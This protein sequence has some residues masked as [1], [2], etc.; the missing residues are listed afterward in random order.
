[1]GKFTNI[2]TT[3]EPASTLFKEEINAIQA[4]IGQVFEQ[5]GNPTH[6]TFILSGQQRGHDAVS[7]LRFNLEEGAAVVSDYTVGYLMQEA[8]G[9]PNAYHLAYGYVP[10]GREFG[11]LPSDIYWTQF[12]DYHSHTLIL[13]TTFGR[14]VA[15]SCSEQDGRVDSEGDKKVLFAV[16]EAI[17]QMGKEDKVLQQSMNSLR[18]S[19]N[20]SEK[21]ALILTLRLFD[22]CDLPALKAWREW[23]E[24]V[25][26]NGE[27]TLFFE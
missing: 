20:A 25:N 15:C 8:L 22:T 5:N 3:V 1:M 27:L 12:D 9:W 26:A 13:N 24:P 21:E 16:A 4:V 11:Q 7:I 6:G 2:Q 23:H 10:Q 17:A 19:A 14:F 18:S